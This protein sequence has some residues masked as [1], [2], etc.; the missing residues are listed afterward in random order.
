MGERETRMQELRDAIDICS[1][2]IFRAKTPKAEQD[3][4]RILQDEYLTVLSLMTGK[5]KMTLLRESS[6]R[7]SEKYWSDR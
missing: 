6:N 4:C 7:C 2:K 3:R 1:E 5:D